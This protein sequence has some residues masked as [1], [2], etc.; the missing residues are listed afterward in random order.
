MLRAEFHRLEGHELAGHPGAA[1]QADLVL[2][3]F[4][5]IH[6]VVHLAF[7]HVRRI[8]GRVVVNVNT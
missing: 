6:A 7:Q 1:V 4:A 8:R 5:K 3:D 2:G